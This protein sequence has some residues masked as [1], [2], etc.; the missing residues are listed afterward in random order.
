MG[1]K[2]VIK[3]EVN[4][5]FENLPLDARKKLAS[6]F[7]YEVPYAR[8]QPSF[9]L[10]RWDGTVSLFGIGGTGYL[11][12]LELILEILNKMGVA[13]DDIE[14]LRKPFNLDFT[15]ITETYWADLGKVWPVGHNDVGKP[16]ML[17]DYQVDA[18]NKFLQQPQALQ[19]IATGAGKCQPY[20][21]NVLTPTGWRTMGELQVGD[22]VITPK[23]ESVSILA[24]H[25][26]GIKDVYELSF[27]DGRAARACEDHI[28]PIYNINWGRS[29][30]GPLRNISTKELVK[31]KSATARSIGIPLVT[32]EHDNNDIELP[33]DPWLMGFLLGDGS[34]RNN[35][36]GFS[37]ADSELIEKVSSKLDE[38]YKV[39]HLTR[40]DYGISFKTDKILQNKRS[41]HMKNK[42]R[43]EKGYIT[44]SKNS[45]HKYIQ[46]LTD[47]NLMETYSHSKFIPEIYFNGSLEQRLEL[48]RGLV[49]SD[50]T[51]DNASVKFTSVSYEL[52]VGFQRLVRSVGGIAKLFTK[53]NNTYM[54]NGIR[55]PCKDSYTVSTKFSKPW[56][57]TSLSRKQN[58]TNFKYQYGNTLKLNITDI[59]LVTT[60]PVKCILIDSPDHLYITDDYIVTHNT[61]TTATLAHICESQ[62][63]TIVIV[64]NKSLVE[65]THE[66]FVTV[67]LDVGMYYGDRKDLNKTHTI[68]TWQSLNI[69]DKKSKNS[70]HDIITLAEFLDGVSA[71]IVDECFSG[72]MRVLT[73]NG[74]V[75]IKDINIGDTIINYCETTNTFK[76]DVVITQHINLTTSNNEK[77]YNLEFDNG[78]NIHVTGNHKFLTTDGWIRADEL[79]EHHTI[80]N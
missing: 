68:C 50:G 48:I 40:Y 5:K 27:Y 44:D 35:H 25:E 54:Y 23:G 29:V 58:I 41:L 51:I 30:A 64:P 65:Q 8:Y 21:S 70:E 57:L 61:I 9:K 12:N 10:G 75:P 7:K 1:V 72:N 42:I 69:L 17:R 66:D 6:A 43:N 76:T 18:V 74:Y 71:V 37:S 11:N 62:G 49:D 77:M 67:D 78:S 33:L 19:E 38:N 59:N 34:F 14:D 53:T 55:T 52:A 4:I 22:R 13:I 36:V 2:L 15:P 80:I 31:L 39:T 45:F 73:T 47:L 79:T 46:I 16:I 3:D 56:M 32:M 20:S 24:I 63:R 26:P 60:E 28:W